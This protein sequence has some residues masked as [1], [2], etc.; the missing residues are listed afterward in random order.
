MP[1]MPRLPAAE[2]GEQPLRAEV[3]EVRRVR[4]GGPSSAECR[5]TR[6]ELA[7]IRCDCWP[8]EGLNV[9][10]DHCSV[11]ARGRIVRAFNEA[12][13][14]LSSPIVRSH[15]ENQVTGRD[16]LD[17]A[18]KKNA[19]LDM[20]S[21]GV[22]CLDDGVTRHSRHA[23]NDERDRALPERRHDSQPMPS[24]SLSNRWGSGARTV[25][26]LNWTSLQSRSGGGGGMQTLG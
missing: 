5:A 23:G 25:K 2:G 11:F 14:R 8:G 1:G 7:N 18:I 20:E 13:G 12:D 22:V 19:H 4:L 15:H 9:C 3:R 16:V 10:L 21:V 26:R 24:L 6:P 17:M